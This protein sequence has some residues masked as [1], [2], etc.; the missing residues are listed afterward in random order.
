MT[1]TQATRTCII[2]VVVIIRVITSGLC[3]GMPLPKS[4][5]LMS[6]FLGRQVRM[7]EINP[8]KLNQ[9]DLE[10]V[11]DVNKSPGLYFVSSLSVWKTFL[12][13]T[14]QTLSLLKRSRLRILECQSHLNNE[15]MA[16][17]K[18]RWHFNLNLKN[19]K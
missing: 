10:T 12:Q 3:V 15:T 13:A 9:V 16:L 18:E 11:N 19:K 14:R 5:W 17:S 4:V 8:L 6:F 7:N 2:T 1:Q